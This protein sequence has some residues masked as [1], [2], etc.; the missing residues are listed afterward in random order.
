MSRTL[1]IWVSRHAPLKS[2][3]NVLKE[4]LGEYELKVVAERIPNAEYIVENF[5]KPNATKYDR[6]VVI[7]VLPLSMIARLTELS[8]RFNFEVWWAE[9]EQVKTLHREPTP[10]KDYDPYDETVVVAAGAHEQVSY[11]IMK[12]KKFH[13]IKRIVMEMEEV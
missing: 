7:P 1:V 4:K 12:F 13:R 10:G 6:I 2:Q 9:M 11:K 3:L 5:I 8:R